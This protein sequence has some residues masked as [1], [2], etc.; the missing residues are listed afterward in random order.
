M[1]HMLYGLLR[2]VISNTIDAFAG[3]LV[4]SGLLAP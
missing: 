3:I 2:T 4:G 1:T